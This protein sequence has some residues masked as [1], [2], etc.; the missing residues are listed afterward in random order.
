[1]LEHWDMATK[2]IAMVLISKSDTRH[3]K[4]TALDLEE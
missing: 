4:D 3:I 1:M 2:L